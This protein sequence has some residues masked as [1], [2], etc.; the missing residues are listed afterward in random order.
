MCSWLLQLLVLFTF[1]FTAEIGDPTV[2][3]DRFN[4]NY[5]ETSTIRLSSAVDCSVTTTCSGLHLFNR[6]SLALPGRRGFYR[7]KRCCSPSCVFISLLLLLGGVEPNPGPTHTSL[8]NFPAPLN[9]GSLNAR[10]AVNKGPLIRDLIESNELDV[11]AVCET[12]IKSDDPNAI[13]FDMAPPGYVTKHFHCSAPGRIGRNSGLALIYRDN[14][15]V[16]THPL[17]TSSSISTS[18]FHFQPLRLT[19]S[20]ASFTIV[21]IYRWPD[22]NINE[23]YYDFTN[24]LS[25]LTTSTG[26]ERLI[27]CGD[28]NCRGDSP[29]TIRSDLIDILDSFSLKQLVSTPTHIGPTGDSLLDLVI[30]GTQSSPIDKVEVRSTHG[31]SDHNLVTWT[32]ARCLNRRQSIKFSYR[33]LKS[34]D[35]DSFR[36]KLMNSELFTK[37]HNTVDEFANQINTVVTDVLDKLGAPLRQL[38]KCPGKKI[39][40]WL[41]EEAIKAKQLRRRFER[42]WKST[43]DEFV[44]RTYRAACR[45]AN[46]LINESRQLLHST[47]IANKPFGS[48]Q[49][50]SAVR[51]VLHSTAPTEVLSH[52]ESEKRCSIFS[53]FFNDKIQS[54]KSVIANQ[55]SGLNLN[56]LGSDKQH[57]GTLLD[58]LKPVESEEIFKL[59]SSLPAKSSPMDMFPSSLL[60]SCA[61]IF[62]PIIAR[63]CNLSFSSGTFPACYRTASITPLLKKD[64]LDPD[65]PSNYRPISNL[66]SIS[67]IIERVFLSRLLPH[68]NE[69]TNFNK[70]QSAYR[71]HHSTETALLKILDDVYTAAG[72]H[73]PTVLIGLDLSAAFDTIDKATL[74]ARLEKTF[75]IGGCAL[76]WI[77]SYLTNRSQHVRIG[78]ST[79]LPSI[80]DFGVPQG[81]VLGP[82][83]FTLY[84][85]PIAD[86]ISAFGINH[87]QY[88]DDTQ[89]YLA[90]DPHHPDINTISR[91][92]EAVCRWFQSNG[93]CLNPSKSEVILLGTAA[94]TRS[95][96]NI[97]TV[98]VAGADI[99]I[100]DTLKS[101]GVIFDSQL[102]FNQHIAS[103][104][105]SSYFHIRAMRHV[106]SCL[107]PQLLQTVACSI[108]TAK[109]DYCNSLLYGT[110]NA[111]IAKLQHVQ[112]SLARLVTRTRKY[113]H[114]S[115]VLAKLHWLPVSARITYKIATLTRKVLTSNQPV[116]LSSSLH[117]RQPPRY[118]RSAEHYR[119]SDTDIRQ[120]PSEFS[121]RGFS[122]SAP[123]VWNN[124]PTNVTDSFRS[125]DIFCKMLKTHLH[126]KFYGN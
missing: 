79:S 59:L 11:L 102:T 52:T 101:L 56:P 55:L 111:N 10:S 84:V 107:P 27:M 83:L 100:S 26:N 98:N 46:K 1:V 25:A 116:Y 93:L 81:S 33:K 58:D 73:K 119:L 6:S 123:T 125:H 109:L 72:L 75:G 24:L 39:N 42:R 90:L 96:N 38:K 17:Q 34:L 47:A 76:E 41:S 4:C 103:T 87:H 112:N 77:H 92:T 86:V 88:A 13:K 2:P 16:R 70:S 74:I 8:R 32:V 97:Q 53:N 5:F 9:F 78:S 30:T 115:P 35:M 61:D 89:L 71:R 124:L 114:I 106:Q 63:L 117:L 3:F 49:Q 54:V 15:S 48:R 37:P 99:P 22:S 126:R 95:Y 18:T 122:N 14:L 31:L 45:L 110:S 12:W 50:W 51:D 121:R 113:D 80:C 28:F 20:N 64:G 60:K 21:N 43:G 91:C 68:V 118:L 40:R 29:S 23:F 57:V 66:N 19:C 62:A 120:F 105:K 94:A 67:K 36:S 82:V 104:C 44:R 7:P 85:S 65:D 108:V 69:S